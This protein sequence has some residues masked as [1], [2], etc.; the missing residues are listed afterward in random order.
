[1]TAAA[2]QRTRSKAAKPMDPRRWLLQQNAHELLQKLEAVIMDPAGEVV[3]RLRTGTRRSGALLESL[4]DK[5]GR[6]SEFRTKR[7]DARKLLRQWKKL[8]RTAGAVRDLD[9]HLDL[10]KT[11]EKAATRA[12]PAATHPLHEQMKNLEIW[13]TQQ[14]E[15]HAKELQ[16]VASKRMERVKALTLVVLGPATPVLESA[17]TALARRG[18]RAPAAL[19]LDDF[20]N[21]SEANPRLDQKNLHD[22][23]KITKQAR[24]VAE[25]GRKQPDAVAVDK[26]LKRIQDAI[27]EW[28]DLDALQLEAEKAL[29]KDGLD[30]EDLLRRQTDKKMRL[31]IESTERMRRRLLGERLALRSRQNLSA[32][33]EN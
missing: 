33:Q 12:A 20:Y 30:L 5:P 19:A 31:A 3:H 29:G 24:Y 21:A 2:K 25:A 8:R 14:R 18:V 22:F 4:L 13:L 17:D 10:L 27:G 11:L 1:M 6:S 28:H 26:A 15:R 32:V 7:G 23:R 16:R 9:V